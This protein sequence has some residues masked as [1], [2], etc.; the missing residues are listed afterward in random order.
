MGN[1]YEE[2]VSSAVNGSWVFIHEHLT[3]VANLAEM[4]AIGLGLPVE[5]FRDAGRYGWVSF[6]SSH[7]I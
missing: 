2:R 6:T 3:S 1:F 7:C 5:T 4:T